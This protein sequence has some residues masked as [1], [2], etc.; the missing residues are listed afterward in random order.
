MYNALINST[1]LYQF[2]F[3]DRLNGYE[4]SQVANC[5]GSKNIVTA[6]N[7]DKK[8]TPLT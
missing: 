5:Q 6:N 3:S 4:D 8:V 2:A 1:T 7:N